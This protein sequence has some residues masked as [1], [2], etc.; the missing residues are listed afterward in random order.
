MVLDLTRALKSATRVRL[1]LFTNATCRNFK[2]TR[3]NEGDVEYSTNLWDVAR[4]HRLLTSGSLHEPI[5][6][7]F[8]ELCGAPLPCLGTPAVDDDYSALLAIVPG[9]VLAKLYGEYG[10]RLLELNV[11]SFLQAKGAVNRGIRETLLR[12]P[13]RFLAYNNG[14]SATASRIEMVDGTESK[15]ILRLHDLQIVNGGQTTA[16]IHAAMQRDGADMSKVLVQA[17]ITVV[18]PERIPDIVPAISKYSNTQNK[19]TTADFSSNDSFHVEMEKLSRSVWA[20]SPTGDGQETHWFYERARGQYA[21]ELS[22]QRTPARVKAWKLA[23]PTRQ[24]FTKTDLAKYVAS[25]DQYPYLVS[26]G[27]EKNFREFM[28]RLSSSGRPRVD[29]SYFRR[30]IAKAILFKEADRIVSMKN[31][32]GYKAN[33]VTYTLAKLTNETKSCVDL[34]AV[35]K[36]QG[37]SPATEQAIAALSELVHSSITNPPGGANIGEWCKRPECWARV[38]RLSWDIPPDLRSELVDQRTLRARDAEEEDNAPELMEDPEVAAVSSVEAQTWFDVSQWAK[39]TGSLQPWQRGLAYGLGQR[40]ERGV[41]PTVKQARQGA[42][43]LEESIRLGFRPEQPV[44][45]LT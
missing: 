19:V 40:A 1:F 29:P 16:S 27:A 7:D 34:D 12:N 44:P 17:K 43:L 30:L 5:V 33:V 22:R 42:I 24:K 18:S 31:F 36:A 9:S 26:R 4:L 13:E 39:Q 28:V 41:P 20:P 6:V 37:L 14:I 8:Q 45:A 25:W 38:Q 11:R 35:W 23:N 15:G 21:D 32:G 3:E 2:S 10:T